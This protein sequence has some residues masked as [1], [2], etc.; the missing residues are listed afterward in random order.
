LTFSQDFLSVANVVKAQL[1]KLINGRQAVL[2]MKNGGSRN[3]RQME[4]I[5]F[6]LE[7]FVDTQVLPRVG[8]KAG[9]EYGRT[10]FDLMLSAPWDLKAHL[11]GEDSVILNDVE[12]VDKC[13]LQHGTLNYMVLKGTA[14]YDDASGRFKKWH[15]GLK[16]KPSA[17]VAAGKAKARRSRRRKVNF[18]R[19]ELIGFHMTSQTLQ[20]GLKSGAVG[21]FQRGM[22][23]SNGRPRRS[24]Y[25]LNLDLANSSF[26]SISIL[27]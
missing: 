27:L 8:G 25:L 18:K 7:F 1:P 6:Y 23:N 9:P 12:A 22:K 2:A 17:Y 19:T 3:W 21:Y 26:P 24:K 16:G 10:K 14:T 5:G 13:L 20:Q 15:D 11:D 4:W